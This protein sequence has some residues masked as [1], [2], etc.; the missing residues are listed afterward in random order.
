[1]ST[2]NESCLPGTGMAEDVTSRLDSAVSKIAEEQARKFEELHATLEQ[3]MNS[4]IEQRIEQAMRD[5][6]ASHEQKFHQFTSTVY[7]EINQKMAQAEMQASQEARAIAAQA[8]EESKS[9]MHAH[10]SR[11]VGMSQEASALLRQHHDEYSAKFQHYEEHTAMFRQRQDEHA[12]LLQQMSHKYDE[13][14]EIHAPNPAPIPNV[15]TMDAVEQRIGT[16]REQMSYDVQRM[17]EDL[18]KKIDHM[19]DDM[20]IERRER[21]GNDCSLSQQI[22]A[23]TA[24]ERNICARM[25][26]LTMEAKNMGETAMALTAQVYS[27][28]ECSLER[29]LEHVGDP[30]YDGIINQIQ[31]LH[32]RLS[33]IEPVRQS[34]SPL[35]GRVGAYEAQGFAAK[36]PVAQ[37]S[38]NE[39]KSVVVEE[40][41]FTEGDGVREIRN[42]DEVD[43]SPVRSAQGT[44]MAAVSEELLR[45]LPEKS[46][47]L[48][49]RMHN[50][51]QH[52]FQTRDLATASADANC[53][54]FEIAS[55]PLRTAQGTNNARVTEEK[56]RGL[57]EKSS[58]LLDRMHKVS[59]HPLGTRDLAIASA[60]SNGDDY[61]MSKIQVV[62]AQAASM[63]QRLNTLQTVDQCG[64][65][66]GVPEAKISELLAR[67]DNLENATAQAYPEK[68]VELRAKVAELEERLRAMEHEKE[69]NLGWTDRQHSS[70]ESRTAVMHERLQKLEG[71]VR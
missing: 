46:A 36:P 58:S 18:M 42:F 14:R 65:P 35:L 1:M 67:V 66:K 53:D 39:T 56:L 21:E 40:G 61:V 62:E 30:R 7:H 71:G 31:N 38:T 24:N 44:N 11:E 3:R 15:A 60:D 70:L 25:D 5:M 51:S 33:E 6:N 54:G 55:S 9:S 17:V 10:M 22:S 50:V 48:L 52:P 43:P 16:F 29:S 4:V 49:E 59:Q 68:F 28:S 8:I 20:A 57:S 69:A 45:G 13:L 2:S 37:G 27:T 34:C 64:Q 12:A 63:E 26:D 47:S 19:N 41:C 23:L 32:S